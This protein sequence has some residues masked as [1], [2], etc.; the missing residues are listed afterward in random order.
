MWSAT[1]VVSR[2]TGVS[3]QWPRRVRHM[4][5]LTTV[6]SRGVSRGVSTLD[7]DRFIDGD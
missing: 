6:Y 4:S 5:R 7:G 3:T 2:V 1:R